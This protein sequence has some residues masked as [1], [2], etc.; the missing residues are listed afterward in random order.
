VDPFLRTALSAAE[1]A[2]RVHRK[3]AAR[4]EAPRASE[5]GY[6]DFVTEVDLEAQEA[7]TEVIRRRHPGH[8]ILAEEELPSTPGGSE[9]GSSGE[10]AGDGGV[11]PGEP[12]WVVDP[13]DGTT[14]F[15][16][17]HPMYAASVGAFVDG[18]PTVGAVVTPAT[19]ERW[20][21][22][23]GG[24]AFKDGRRI[25]VSERRELRTALIGTGF[26]FKVLEMLP[27]YLDQFERVLRSSA[28]MRRGGSA[29]LD[30]C[31][32]A[33]GVFDAFWELY[34]EPW[35]VAGALAILGEAG[36]VATRL[37]GGAVNLEPGTLLAANSPAML[38]AL[39]AVVHGEGGRQGAS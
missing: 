25:R 3:H 26:P 2:A 33:E 7:A 27:D 32:L 15:L 36:G 10:G 1:A 8:R 5:K 39:A 18:E 20:W 34:L 37:D 23:R 17:R 38:R 14:N 35:D 31:H 30:L 24:G 28:G 6:S 22:R 12:L 13:L 4:T 9:E 16:H 11:S 29:A 19:G 21:A